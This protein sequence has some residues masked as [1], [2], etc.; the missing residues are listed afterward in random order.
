LSG[1]L[2]EV[3]TGAHRAWIFVGSRLALRHRRQIY[4]RSIPRTASAIVSSASPAIFPFNPNTAKRMLAVW[5]TVGGIAS[6]NTFPPIA[7]RA[8]REDKGSCS[9]NR[10]TRC[11]RGLG[12]KARRSCLAARRS[13][14]QSH[15]PRH[16]PSREHHHHSRALFPHHRH[17]LAPAQS[18]PH[19]FRR[20]RR[21]NHSQGP[22][23]SK[24]RGLL[25]CRRGD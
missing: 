19:S 17:P 7:L 23:S 3:R 9:S 24:P 16:R 2:G 18:G 12:S 8:R 10:T 20:S 14:C 5:K 4:Q 22:E 6:R 15:I 1:S 21:R 25:H 13:N 11:R